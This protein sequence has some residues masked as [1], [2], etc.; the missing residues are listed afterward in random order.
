MKW[1]NQTPTRPGFYYW[2]GG[3]LTGMEVAIVQITAFRDPTIPLEA[4]EMR[5]NG[6][7][8]APEVGPANKWG[9]RWAGPFPQPY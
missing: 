4:A 1:T 5:I 6:W 9:G 7:A 3:R 2:Q 8:N